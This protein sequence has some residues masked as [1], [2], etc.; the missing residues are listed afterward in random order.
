L[1]IFIVKN[2]LQNGQRISGTDNKIRKQLI[3][4]EKGQANILQTLKERAEADQ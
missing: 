4:I 1:I 3:T 2:Y